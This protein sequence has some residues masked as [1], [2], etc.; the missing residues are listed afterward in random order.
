MNLTMSRAQYTR[1]QHPGWV[2]DAFPMT[3]LS[4]SQDL[5]PLGRGRPDALAGRRGK[6]VVPRLCSR[7]A[8]RLDEHHAAL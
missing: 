3:V 5:V 4:S 7:P 6:V 1:L 2:I 8:R